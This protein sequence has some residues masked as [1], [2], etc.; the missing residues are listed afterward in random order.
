MVNSLSINNHLALNTFVVSQI[1]ESHCASKTSMSSSDGLEVLN[2]YRVFK[3]SFYLSMYN[4]T[5]HTLISSKFL[6]SE[7]TQSKIQDL[8]ESNFHYF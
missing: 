8:Y 4:P 1:S 3:K 7:E 2:I 5:L 6:F